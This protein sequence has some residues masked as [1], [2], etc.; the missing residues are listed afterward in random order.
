MRK[1]VSVTLIGRASLVWPSVLSMREEVSA[2]SDESSTAPYPTIGLL[3]F[4]NYGHTD[5]N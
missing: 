1:L 4:A 5:G 2:I 3:P